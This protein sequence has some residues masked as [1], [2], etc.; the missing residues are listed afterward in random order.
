[1]LSQSSSYDSDDNSDSDI[2]NYKYFGN[3]QI[4]EWYKKRC[5]DNISIFTEISNPQITCIIDE[6]LYK[7]EFDTDEPYE[8]AI[9]HAECLADPDDDGNYP[10]KVNGETF[11]IAG[12]L[13]DKEDYDDSNDDDET[14]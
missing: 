12:T 3:E 6:Y 2:D 13:V 8:E 14:Q 1:M 5:N 7:L 10:V 11:L 9:I 4:L